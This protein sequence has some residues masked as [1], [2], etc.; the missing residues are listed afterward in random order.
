MF[1]AAGRLI[2]EEA[3]VEVGGGKLKR[4]SRVVLASQQAM[5]HDSKSLAQPTEVM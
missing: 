3:L 2:K 5:G 4:A 1:D